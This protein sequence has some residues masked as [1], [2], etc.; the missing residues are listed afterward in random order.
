MNSKIIFE[1]FSQKKSLEPTDLIEATKTLFSEVKKPLEQINIK[2]LKFLIKS[3]A[4]DPNQNKEEIP[5]IHYLCRENVSKDF[6]QKILKLKLNINDID[7]NSTL[8]TALKN[9]VSLDIIKLL[10]ESGAEINHPNGRTPIF[11]SCLCSEEY[12]KYFLDLKTDIFIVDSMSIL[13]FACAH[14]ASFKI[15]QLLLESGLDKFIQEKNGQTPLHLACSNC[16]SLEI[17]DILLKSGANSV[18]NF[19]DFITPLIYSIEANQSIEILRILLESG[20]N[21]LL[22]DEKTPLHYLISVNE[23]LKQKLVLFLNYGVD[24]NQKD[25][26]ELNDQSKEFLTSYFSYIQDLEIIS[27]IPETWDLEVQTLT[28][29]VGFHKVWLM[30]RVGG[31]TNFEKAINYFQN[32]DQAEVEI[33]KK[34]IYSATQIDSIIKNFANEIGNSSLL[35]RNMKFQLKKDLSNLLLEEETKDFT[36]FVGDSMIKIHKFVLMLRSEL[37]LQMFIN[38]NDSSNSVHDYSNKSFK[39]LKGL[40]DFFYSDIIHLDDEIYQDLEDAKIFYQLNQNSFL[41]YHL[42]QFSQ[43]K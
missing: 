13:H 25:K 5:F 41:D 4:N 14:N 29:K 8:H 11:Y 37:F 42:Q 38:V 3:E 9:H 16:V 28:G 20:A 18:I 35:E 31:K 6:F 22:A 26:P 27:K 43:K 34:F 1:K 21:P 19:H 17:I 7:K 10:V 15:I 32:K 30:K 39:A 24:L 12:L 40:T 2:F 23:D 33:I 36:L